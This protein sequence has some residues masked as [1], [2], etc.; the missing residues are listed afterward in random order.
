L[1][2]A[3]RPRQGNER[4]I[5]V[6]APLTP[7]PRRDTLATASDGTRQ[8]LEAGTH[9]RIFKQHRLKEWHNVIVLPLSL[10]RYS[11]INGPQ[12][13]A[14]ETSPDGAVLC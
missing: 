10:R 6:N 8:R 9:I 12:P 5:A 4:E 3:G 13:E 2:I 11:H 14:D 1:L 7:E